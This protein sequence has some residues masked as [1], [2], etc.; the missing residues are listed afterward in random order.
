LAKTGFR[1][2]SNRSGTTPA[3]DWANYP[4]ALRNVIE[5]L[6][7]VVIENRDA[8]ALIPHH[9]GTQTLHYV[10]PPYVAA[11]RDQGSDYRH[12]LSDRKHEE[13]S[14]LLHGLQGMVVLSGYPSDLY[15]SL[16]GDWVRIERAAH[17]DGARDRIEC[18]WFNPAAEAAQQQAR[19]IA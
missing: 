15:E 1:A 5:R 7:G 11:T 14:D 3:H 18:L 12:E 8:F 17:A 13:L 10:D 2:N 19:L 6:Q 4:A 16:Y 9:D